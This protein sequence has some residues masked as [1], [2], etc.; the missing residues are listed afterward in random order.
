MIHKCEECGHRKF[1]W[2][3][4]VG[5]GLATCLRCKVLNWFKPPRADEYVSREWR[6]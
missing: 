6:R 1:F 5:W 3:C 2:H 4:Q